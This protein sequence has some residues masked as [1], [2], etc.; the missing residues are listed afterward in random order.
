MVLSIAI[1]H[2]K[3]NLSEYF[4]GDLICIGYDFFGLVER[5]IWSTVKL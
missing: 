4:K 5:L 3:N 1:K 2:E